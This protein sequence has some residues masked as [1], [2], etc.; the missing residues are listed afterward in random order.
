MIRIIFIFFTIFTL[1]S[2][3]EKEPVIIEID[4]SLNITKIEEGFN[5]YSNT[6]IL[7]LE[8]TKGNCDSASLE[9]LDLIYQTVKEFYD[10]EY[11]EEKIQSIK[12]SGV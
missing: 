6:G 9:T 7:I 1:Y 4:A 11:Q 3:A 10:I 8:F 5:I 12:H 2:C